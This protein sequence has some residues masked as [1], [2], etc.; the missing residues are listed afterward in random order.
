MKN[1]APS[2]L[3]LIVEVKANELWT[4]LEKRLQGRTLSHFRTNNTSINEQV[5][6]LQAFFSSPF[7]LTSN[8]TT[9]AFRISI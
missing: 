9:Q 8:R 6:S 3:S 4:L 5:L 1:I 2:I 7:D